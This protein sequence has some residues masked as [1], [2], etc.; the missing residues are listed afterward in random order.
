M[1]CYIYITDSSCVLGKERRS[2]LQ[3]GADIIPGL[4]V[5]INHQD[6]RSAVLC[7]GKSKVFVSDPLASLLFTWLCRMKIR[8]E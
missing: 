6:R 1:L 4:L 3:D 7:V 2:I 5:S 8:N